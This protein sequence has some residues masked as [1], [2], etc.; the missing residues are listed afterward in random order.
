MAPAFPRATRDRVFDAFFSTRRAQNGTGMG[1][2]I[3][4]NILSAHGA[5]I[6][7]LPPQTPATGACFEL[8]F[9]APQSP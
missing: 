1:L 3:L 4:R 6:A 8:I 9:P 2:F 7:L 5:R